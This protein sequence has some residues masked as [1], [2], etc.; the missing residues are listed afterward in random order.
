MQFEVTLQGPCPWGFRLGDGKDNETPLVIAKTTAGGKAAKAQILPSD[1]ILKIND[2]STVGMTVAEGQQILKDASELKLFI[3]RCDTGVQKTPR[4][5]E[6]PAPTVREH[7]DPNAPAGPG[8]AKVVHLQYNSPVG[9]YSSANIADAFKGQTAGLAPGTTGI[10]G[11]E[12]NQRPVDKHSAVF[13]AVHDSSPNP[14]HGAASE[15][16]IERD[17]GEEMRYHGYANPGLQSRSFKMLQQM[18]NEED[19]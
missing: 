9:I 12:G 18:V 5:G 10:I 14:H 11:G 1:V 3:Q 8:S 19:L 15:R 4:R 2:Q 7:F 13:Q 6:Q 17:G 16:Y